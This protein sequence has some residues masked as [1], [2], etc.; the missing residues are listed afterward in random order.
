MRAVQLDHRLTGSLQN[1]CYLIWVFLVVGL[2]K[3]S[4]R[5]F[6]QS[7]ITK[8]YLIKIFWLAVFVQKKLARQDRR[9]APQDIAKRLLNG[10]SSINF[11]VISPL[12][13]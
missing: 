13:L 2:Q 11:F 5:R 9:V 8:V 3:G 7:K 4:K 1:L 10:L 12:I 6:W